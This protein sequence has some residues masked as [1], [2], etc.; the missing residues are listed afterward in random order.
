MI[1]I[2]RIDANNND[3]RQL[4][5]KLDVELAGLDGDEHPFYAQFNKIDAIKFAVLAYENEVALGCGAIKEYEPGIMEIKRMYVIPAKRGIGV[6]S[7]ILHE[8][9]K[10]AKELGFEKCILETGKRQAAAIGLYLKQG[11]VQIPNYGQY[12]DVTNSL[13]FE[14]RLL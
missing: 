7:A 12:K 9:E 10:W 4:V 13:C 1:Q 3:L 6:A 5:N 2:T 14:K 11:Y 8:L